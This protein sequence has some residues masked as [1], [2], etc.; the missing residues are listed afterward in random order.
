MHEPGTIVFGFASLVEIFYDSDNRAQIYNILGDA[1]ALTVFE[2]TAGAHDFSIAALMMGHN[3]ICANLDKDSCLRGFA[4]LQ[5]EVFTRVALRN[6]PLRLPFKEM[7]VHP[8]DAYKLNIEGRYLPKPDLV[9][10]HEANAKIAELKPHRE[11][12]E[13]LKASSSLHVYSN[14]CPLLIIQHPCRA[15]GE[16]Q[17]GRTL[18]HGTEKYF[19]R[20]RGWSHNSS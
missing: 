12:C 13:G 9:I 7:L 5:Q 10:Y 17:I 14:Q 19:F 6:K 15:A 18:Y 1:S 3:I 11:F 2:T 16:R 20:Y 8:A 4:R